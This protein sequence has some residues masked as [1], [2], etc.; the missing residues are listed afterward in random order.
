MNGLRQ[1]PRDSCLAWYVIALQVRGR[2]DAA[3]PVHQASSSASSW[4]PSGCGA[5]PRRP[6]PA[7]VR[8]HPHR[9]TIQHQAGLGGM[10][11]ALIDQLDLHL[12]RGCQT[13]VPEG[14]NIR[15]SGIPFSQPPCQRKSK[16]VTD[17]RDNSQ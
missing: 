12:I 14:T 13:W 6:P 3:S 11:R 16:K 9:T 2:G 4:G 17:N 7:Y 10:G 8:H 15:L 1:R 5:L